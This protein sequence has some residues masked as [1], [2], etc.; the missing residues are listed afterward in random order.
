MRLG[1]LGAKHLDVFGRCRR[2]DLAR[3]NVSRSLSRCCLFSLLVFANGLFKRNAQLLVILIHRR[4]RAVKQAFDRIFSGLF[5]A[6]ATIERLPQL[7]LQRFHLFH[8]VHG[9]ALSGI[10]PL[11]HFF[12]TRPLLIHD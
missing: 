2:D 9:S 10:E 12:F 3:V 6:L 4:H 11:T 5:L 8:E 7:G 1:P